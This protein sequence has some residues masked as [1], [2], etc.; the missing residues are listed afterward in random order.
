MIGNKRLLDLVKLAFGPL[1]NLFSLKI[2]EMPENEVAVIGSGYV[3]LVWLDRD[4]VSVKYVDVAQSTGLATIDLGS[5][6]AMK[7]TWTV[8]DSVPATGD[9]ESQVHRGLMSFAKTLES[10]GPD[11]LEGCK[12]WLSDVPDAPLKL[13]TQHVELIRELM[14]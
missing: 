4:G 5:F 14:I 7:R 6:L 10:A 13:S 2:R 3:L 9:F 1:C 12:E 11:I 8:D